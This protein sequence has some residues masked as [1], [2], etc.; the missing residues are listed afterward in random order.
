MA[1]LYSALLLQQHGV[2]VKIFEANDRV[3]GRVFTHK[4]STEPYQYYDTGAMR[5][6][7]VESHKPVFMLIN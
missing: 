5:I 4:F 1:S 2:K 3:G 6:P 7:N